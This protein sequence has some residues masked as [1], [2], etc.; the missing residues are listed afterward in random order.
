MVRLPFFQMGN[1]CSIHW[2]QSKVLDIDVF[3]EKFGS[4]LALMLS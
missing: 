1:Q 4:G 3:Y 2:Q